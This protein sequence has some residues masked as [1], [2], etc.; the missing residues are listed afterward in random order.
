M[1]KPENAVPTH[2]FLGSMFVGFLQGCFNTPLECTPKP[3]RT[4]HKGIH[5]IVKCF[6]GVHMFSIHRQFWIGLSKKNY[7][8][9]FF[10]LK[11]E[12]PSQNAI[13]GKA[14][15]DN[16]LLTKKSTTEGVSFVRHFHTTNEP[17]KTC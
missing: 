12:H 7:A 6:S 16:H 9:H 15:S 17:P 2:Q 8:Y 1:F 10:F 14:Q 3:L 5:F 13:A 11:F 4:G